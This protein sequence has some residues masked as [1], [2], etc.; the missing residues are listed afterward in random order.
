M[1][2]A[3]PELLT[4]LALG[5]PAPDESTEDH[6]R[7]CTECR[8]ELAALRE[9]T[10]IGRETRAERDLPMP[11]ERV[12]AGIAAETGQS[13]E[14]APVIALA[15]PRRRWRAFLAVAAAAAIVGAA[16]SI[17]VDRITTPVTTEQVLAK[18]D[19]ARLTAAPGSARG[20]ASVVRTADRTVLRIS[21]D[22]MPAPDG[23]Y[24]VWLFDG[25]ATMIPLGVL[26][27]GQTD[28]PIPDAIDLRTYPVVDVSAQRLGQQEHGTSM[29]QGKLS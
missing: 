7:T 10:A 26:T 5:E 21:V 18:T 28:M 20:T 11:S 9:V 29:L 23:L 6:L 2:H 8:S 19:L 15:R 12:W 25:T 14:P 4:L 13:A 22:G 27:N 17:A 16:G 24:Q 3:D 1:A